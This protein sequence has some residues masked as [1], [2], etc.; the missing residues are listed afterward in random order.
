MPQFLTIDASVL[1]SALTSAEVEHRES[2]RFIESLRS[3]NCLLVL[4]TLVRPEIAGAITRI[5]GNPDAGRRAARLAFLPAPAT[6]VQL[7]E[8]LAHEAA[9]VAASARLRGADA[10]YAAVARRFDTVLVTLDR[11][12]KHKL[13]RSIACRLP[14]EL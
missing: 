13:P 2:L 14:E 7:D 1:V 8:K 4:P 3:S 5:T 9:D 12:M 10:V 11:E 6:F